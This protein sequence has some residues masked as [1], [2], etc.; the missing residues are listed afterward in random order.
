[1]CTDSPLTRILQREVVGEWH[2]VGYLT[3]TNMDIVA[4]RERT[5]R[6]FVQAVDRRRDRYNYGVSD[7]NGVWLIVGENRAWIMDGDTVTVPGYANLYT[8]TLYDAHK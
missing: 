3:T 8:V 7:A 1:M 6:L 2:V 4:T 5:M